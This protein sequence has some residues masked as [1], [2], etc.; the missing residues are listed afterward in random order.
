LIVA[1]ALSFATVAA[2]QNGKPMDPEECEI[3]AA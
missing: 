3:I 2:R 1:V